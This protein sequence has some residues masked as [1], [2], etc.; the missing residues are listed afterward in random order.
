MYRWRKN[1][2]ER[3][4][5]TNKRTNKKIEAKIRTQA[6]NI[7][8][9]WSGREERYILEHPEMTDAE[10]AI[11]LK[12]TRHGVRRRRYILDFS[13]QHHCPPQ[14]TTLEDVEKFNDTLIPWDADEE[15]FLRDNYMTLSD[16]QL[17]QELARLPGGVGH[18][19]WRLRL[20]RPRHTVPP[21]VKKERRLARE[22]AHRSENREAYRK[23][24]RLRSAERNKKTPQQEANL[25][26]RWTPEEV[27]F[28]VQNQH[29]TTKELSETLQRSR[30]S[31][32]YKRKKLK[33]TRE[34]R[35]NNL[36]TPLATNQEDTKNNKQEGNPDATT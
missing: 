5:E 31:V 36:P 28:L 11:T 8:R 24:W 4:Q 34:T 22:R 12:R 19:R 3:V 33:L 26:R 20:L 16:E 2:R 17:G 7:G 1:N 27:E 21:E 14:K 15:Q 13:H 10:L 23:R 32:E 6:D 9:L 29:L 30:K 35:N 18:K 25:Y